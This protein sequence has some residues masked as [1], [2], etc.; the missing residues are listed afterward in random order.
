MEELVDLARTTVDERVK[1]VCLIAILDRGGVVPR[2]GD[3]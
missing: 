1:A 2:A 3:R